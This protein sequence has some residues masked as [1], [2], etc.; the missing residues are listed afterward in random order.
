MATGTLERTPTLRR[1]SEF[2]VVVRVERNLVVFAGSRLGFL[3]WV[4][5]A[6]HA[7]DG[8]ADDLWEGGPG[9]NYS[10]E[11]RIGRFRA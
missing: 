6:E 8:R 9:L 2:W 3:L 7:G 1:F 5:G 10:L 11:P 4:D